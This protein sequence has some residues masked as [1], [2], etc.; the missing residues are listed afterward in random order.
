MKKMI[1]VTILTL[2]FSF[3]ALARKGR[4]EYKSSKV[5]A[6]YMMPVTDKLT[7]VAIW[8]VEGVT[9]LSMKNKLKVSFYSNIFFSKLFTNFL[10]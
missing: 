6:S 7:K 8:P 4:S 5:R 1:V 2:L 9:W 3:S 10:R